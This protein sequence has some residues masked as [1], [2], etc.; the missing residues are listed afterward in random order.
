MELTTN[1]GNY[2]NQS[3][4]GYMV[5]TL[6]SEPAKNEI[7]DL[8]DIFSSKYPDIVWKTPLDA[9]HI[10]LLDWLAPLVDYAE[11]KDDAFKRI[12]PGYDAVLTNILREVGPISLNFDRM[13][14]SPSA[15]ALVASD[16]GTRFYNDIRQKFLGK[17]NLLPGT[18]QPPTIAHSTIIRFVGEVALDSIK[19]TAQEIHFSFIEH[20]ESFQLVRETTLPMLDYSVIKKYPLLSHKQN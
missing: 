3:A 2:L 16:E 10:T 18:K 19:D 8:Q 12:Y 17:I 13:I 1:S 14:V 9:L 5:N 20:T 11:N 4:T 15:I 6:L 7:K